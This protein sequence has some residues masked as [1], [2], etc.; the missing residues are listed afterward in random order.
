L[1]SLQEA[2]SGREA[3]EVGVR[4]LSQQQGQVY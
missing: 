4:S 2:E 1:L 3:V